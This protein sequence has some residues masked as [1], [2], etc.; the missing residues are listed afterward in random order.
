MCYTKSYQM[1]HRKGMLILT[2]L[3]VSSLPRKCVLNRVEHKGKGK[4]HGHEVLEIKNRNIPTDRGKTVRVT[5]PRSGIVGK[6][7]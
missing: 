2:G 6:I 3:R 7:R 1:L 4:A 5:T